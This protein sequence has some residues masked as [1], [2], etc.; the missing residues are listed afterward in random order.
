MPF[1]ESFVSLLLASVGAAALAIFAGA[2]AA[3]SAVSASEAVTAAQAVKQMTEEALLWYAIAGGFIGAITSWAL[4]F[5]PQNLRDGSKQVLGSALAAFIFGPLIIL[6]FQIPQTLV[7][8]ICVC[9]ILGLTSSAILLKLMPFIPNLLPS[10]LK[11]KGIDPGEYPQDDRPRAPRPPPS[12]G[13]LGTPAPRRRPRGPHL[14][15]DGTNA[16]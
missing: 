6:Y 3:N 9:G 15:D 13:G 7:I 1:A 8:V 16:P 10:W 5:Q 14:D 11:S 2:E 12:N 4:G